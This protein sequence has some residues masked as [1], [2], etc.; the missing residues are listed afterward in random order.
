MAIL[1]WFW[2]PLWNKQQPAHAQTLTTKYKCGKYQ[3]ML[4]CSLVPGKATTTPDITPGF[5]LCRCHSFTLLHSE[6]CDLRLLILCNGQILK[7]RVC[8]NTRKTK[9]HYHHDICKA[10]VTYD[11]FR[12]YE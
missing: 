2:V 1:V 8:W 3:Q 5:S 4:D 12:G 7:E 10:L 6:S 9:K 11:P